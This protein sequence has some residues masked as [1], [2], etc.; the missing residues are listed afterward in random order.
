M[1][2]RYKE[3]NIIIRTI[4]SPFFNR[5]RAEKFRE[6]YAQEGESEEPDKI[7][8]TR[9]IEVVTSRLSGLYSWTSWTQNKERKDT[10]LLNSAI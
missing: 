7:I 2:R 1:L 9:Q 6:I 5:I 10:A 4:T 8:R 3:I